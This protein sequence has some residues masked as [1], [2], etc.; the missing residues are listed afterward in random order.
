MAVLDRT[1]SML[2]VVCVLGLIV[3]VVTSGFFYATNLPVVYEAI[4][5]VDT[6]PELLDDDGRYIVGCD[7]GTAVYRGTSRKC[8]K[9]LN[10]KYVHEWIDRNDVDM[11]LFA[12]E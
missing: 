12:D 5:G 4:P 11:L 6:P 9:I 3:I 10:G 8:R 1:D 2:L 7:N